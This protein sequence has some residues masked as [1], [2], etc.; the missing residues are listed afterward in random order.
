MEW[1]CFLF[2]KCNESGEPVASGRMFGSQF[3]SYSIICATQWG[4]DTRRIEMRN[5]SDYNEESWTGQINMLLTGLQGNPRDLP[6]VFIDTFYDVGPSEFASSKFREN[7]ARL[8]EVGLEHRHP[9]QCKDIEIARSE[10]M[11][12]QQRLR[13]MSL[14]L[15]QMEQEKQNLVMALEMLKQKEGFL[16]LELHLNIFF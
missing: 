8:L 9:F 2:S 6:S 7:T 14:M 4:Y 10:I 11:E 5:S 13:Q 15:S 12:Q 1:N 3:W 16:S